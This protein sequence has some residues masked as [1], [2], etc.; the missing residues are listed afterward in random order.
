MGVP[1]T[2]DR[3][4]RAGEAEAMTMRECEYCHEA[5]ADV[6]TRRLPPPCEDEQPVLCGEC[7]RDVQGTWRNE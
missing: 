5:R 6:R 4:L 1:W 2:R 7:F 3:A